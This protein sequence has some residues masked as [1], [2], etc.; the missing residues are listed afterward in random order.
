MMFLPNAT[1]SL[2][3]RNTPIQQIIS[4]F[5][6]PRGPQPRKPEFSDAVPAPRQNTSNM[7]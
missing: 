7:T 3:N 2:F 4:L 5:K 6:V 1:N